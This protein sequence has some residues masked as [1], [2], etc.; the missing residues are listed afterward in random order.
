MNCIESLLCGLAS[1][2]SNVM[3]KTYVRYEPGCNTAKELRI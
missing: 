2:K 3:R 1:A